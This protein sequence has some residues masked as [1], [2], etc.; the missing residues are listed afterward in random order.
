MTRLLS[1]IIKGQRIRSESIVE[2]EH[3][4]LYVAQDEMDE[5]PATDPQV[6]QEDMNQKMQKAQS[7]AQRIIQEAEDEARAKVAVIFNEGYETRTYVHP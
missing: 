3:T 2:I 1:S 5:N 4:N 7:K 6:Q